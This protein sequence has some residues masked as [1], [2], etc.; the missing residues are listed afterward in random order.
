MLAMLVS[1]ATVVLTDLS[2]PTQQLAISVQLV[3][4]VMPPV[5][6]TVLLVSLVSSKVLTVQMLV[7]LARK[8]TTASV[9][10]LV[11][12]LAQLVTSVLRAQVYT[13]TLRRNPQQ[14]TTMWLV[15]KLLFR[16]LSAPSRRSLVSQL[17][18]IASKV[19]GAALLHLQTLTPTLS[20]LPVSTVH[21]SITSPQL[22]QSPTTE[23]CAQLVLTKQVS[24]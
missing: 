4:T 5:S 14:A 13:M 6:T 24:Q 3:L 18:L 12:L 17:A 9:V 22:C 11:Q 19:S 20:A 10:T 23:R 16:A 2:L 21:R 15:R 1:C 7:L 8:V